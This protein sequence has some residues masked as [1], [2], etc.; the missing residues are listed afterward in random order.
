VISVTGLDGITAAVRR[1]ER[2]E[3]EFPRE[4]RKALRDVAPR[5]VRDARE[6]ADQVLPRRGGYARQVARTTQFHVTVS[7]TTAGMVL[8]IT[9]TGP[10][11]RLDTQGQLRHPVYARGPRSDWNWADATQKVTPGWFSRPMKVNSQHVRVVLVAATS[12]AVRGR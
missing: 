12:R 5:L 10:D 9:A 1:L 6:H 8:E 3:R 4:V 2:A 11:K 7:R